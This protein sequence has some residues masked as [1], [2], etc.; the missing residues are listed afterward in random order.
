MDPCAPVVL[1]FLEDT[2]LHEL[3]RR[4]RTSLWSEE[5]LMIFHSV[6]ED[7]FVTESYRDL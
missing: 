1:T 5:S 4:F 3:T 2:R 6:K 7:I